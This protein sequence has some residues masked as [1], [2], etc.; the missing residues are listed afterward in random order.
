MRVVKKKF[1]FS[2]SKDEKEQLQTLTELKQS[3]EYNLG[4]EMKKNGE[5]EKEIT[6]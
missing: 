2:Q 6:E 5:L 3:L 1:F 4:E